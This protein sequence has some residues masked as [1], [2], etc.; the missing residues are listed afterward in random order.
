MALLEDLKKTTEKATGWHRP[1]ADQL[2]GLGRPGKV[3]VF[4]FADDGFVPNHPSWP[5]VILWRAVRL[6][7]SVDPAAVFEDLFER[8]GWGDSWRGDVYDYLHYHSR[9]P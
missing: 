2:C 9:I 8:N 3:G 1:A 5:L 4:R 6:P 7:R